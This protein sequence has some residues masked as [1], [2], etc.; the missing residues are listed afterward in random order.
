MKTNKIDCRRRRRSENCGIGLSTCEAKTKLG[1]VLARANELVSVRFNPGSDANERLRN[2][3]AFR[4][5]RFDAIDLVERID[6]DATDTFGHRTPE[7]RGA[8][9]V[10]VQNKT[11][12]GNPCRTGD[13]ILASGRHIEIA[14]FFDSK[15]GH[16]LAKERLGR[17]IH[18]DTK[19]GNCFTTTRTKVFFVVD[20]ERRTELLSE[21]KSVAATDDELALVA[22]RGRI[23]Q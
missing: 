3:Q 13:V 17:E 21:F 23:G 18:A 1:I 11:I 15:A 16:R 4:N 7:F 5:E 8:L 12:G 2:R 22:N 14:A 20:K 19:R 10:P 9:V 6:D